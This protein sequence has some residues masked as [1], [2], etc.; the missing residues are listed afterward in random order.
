MLSDYHTREPLIDS[1]AALRKSVSRDCPASCTGDGP[2]LANRGNDAV[3]PEEACRASVEL[4]S[5]TLTYMVLR[6]FPGK[7]YCVVSIAT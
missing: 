7:N 5:G 4:L 6:R 1:T 2:S 3:A